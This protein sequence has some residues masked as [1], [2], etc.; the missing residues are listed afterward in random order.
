MEALWLQLRVGD[1]DT[2]RGKCKRL[3]VARADLTQ[4]IIVFEID[5]EE[6]TS[7]D[8]AWRTLMDTLVVGDYILD[9]TTGRKR[10]T[11]G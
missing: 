8:P 3:C 7:F 5:P 1:P 11:R 6:E 4:A 10:M 9:P 2:G